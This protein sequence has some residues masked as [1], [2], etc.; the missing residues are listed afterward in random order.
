[1]KP[2]S[3]ARV[4]E[5]TNRLPRLKERLTTAVILLLVGVIMLTTVSFAWLT[6]SQN[7]EATNILTSIASNGNLEIALASG[8]R[9]TVTAPGASQVGDGNLPIVEGNLTWGNMVNLSDPSYGLGNLVLRPASLNV[10]DLL[11]EP[12]KAK[13]YDEAGRPINKDASFRYAKWIQ[14]DVNDQDSPWEFQLSNDLGVRAISST[15]MAA[16]SGYTYNLQL[17]ISAAKDANSAA[18]T[19]YL[20]ITKNYDIVDQ[21]EK[22]FLEA[23]AAVMGAYMTARMN[24]D[25]QSLANA[26]MVKEDMEALRDLFRAFGKVLELERE[27]ML[28]LA[29]LQLFVIYN[30]DTTLYTEFATVDELVAKK[31]QLKSMGLQISGLTQN[32]SD[33]EKLMTNYDKLVTICEKGTIK[34]GDDNLSSIVNSLINVGTC[35]VNGTPV[36]NIGASVAMDLNGKSCKTIITNGILYNFEQRTGARMNV[37]KG[38]TDLEAQY[39]KGLPV[40]AT[41]KVVITVNGTIYALITTSATNPSLFQKDLNYA[42]DLNKGG[43]AELTANDTYGFAIDF[44]VRTN[45]SGSFLTLEGNILTEQIEEDAKGEDAEGNEVQLYTVTLKETDESGEE[46]EYTIDLYMVEGSGGSQTWYNADTHEEYTVDE[47]NPPKKKVIITENIIGYE[48]ENRIWDNNAFLS[49]DN[50]TQ[51]SGSCYVYYAETPEDMA[52][53]LKLLSALN[54][55]FV[56]QNGTLMAEGYMDTVNYFVDNGKVIVPLRL[57]ANSIALQNSDGSETLAI[58]SLDQ[59]VAKLITAIVYLDGTKVE[60]K[61]VLAVSDIQGQL[62]IQFGSSVALNA[63]SDEELASKSMSVSASADVTSF[64]YDT[65]LANGTPMTT[66]LTVNV[67]GSK[68]SNV[69]AFFIRAISS[70]QGIPMNSEDEM[71]IFEDKGGGVW[72]AEYTFTSPGNYVLRSVQVDGIEY[73]LDPETRPQIEVK[74]FSLKSLSWEATTAKEQSFMT[75][76]NSVSAALSLEFVTDDPERM[77]TRVEG[78]F[79]R[80]DGNSVNVVFSRNVTTNQWT[81]KATFLSSGTYTLQYLVFNGEYHEVDASL[82]KVANVYVGMKVSIYTNSPTSF[83]F[84]YGVDGDADNGMTDNEQNLYMQVKIM[85]DTGKEMTRL[86]NVKLYYAMDGYN[87]VETGLNADITWNQSTGYYEGAFETKVG[88]FKFLYVT[89]DGNTITQAT[90]SPRFVI[91]SPEPPKFVEAVNDQYQYAPDN[92]AVLNVCLDNSD[93]IAEEYM[94]GY[95]SDG[96]NLYDVVGVN[97]GE[98]KWSFKIPQLGSVQDG[99]WELQKIH[100]I[101]G[102]IEDEVR[103]DENP[104]VIDMTGK[105]GLKTTVVSTIKVTLNDTSAKEFNGDFLAE[106]KVDWFGITVTDRFDQALEGIGDTV[107]LYYTYQDNSKDYGGYGIDT[108]LGEK[109]LVKKITLNK[110]DGTTFEQSDELVLNHAGT[111]VLTK[112]QFSFMGKGVELEDKKLPTAP[113][114]TV[115]STAP[116]VSIKEITTYKTS[117]MTSDGT[118]ATVYFDYKAENKTIGCTEYTLETYTQPTVTINLTGIGN[119]TKATLTF[120]HAD[121]DATVHLYTSNGGTT[122]VSSYEWTANGTVLRWIGQYKSGSLNITDDTRT[123]AGTLTANEIVL[124]DAAGYSYKVT[125]GSA[126]TINN[127]S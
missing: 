9:Y 119:A 80:T 36:N 104:Y 94:I 109:D 56:D 39:P 41:G 72:E 103:S 62:N 92:D 17:R 43:T 107:T 42:N 15:K 24:S 81:G 58:T 127:P 70:T 84:G 77:P 115:R 61:D 87:K 102:Y 3:N 71:L 19:A 55:A 105:S 34:W 122:A 99:T 26:T 86:S 108:S 65:C 51:G 44:W 10:D 20:N 23:L 66:K 14:T 76:A 11:N 2:E 27:A 125:L 1:M 38:S 67:E 97:Q 25:D 120:A 37:P 110:K 50:T 33:S 18:E 46:I 69:T 112:V 126:I 121:A 16:S 32:L 96:T 28:K 22:P 40:T 45:A 68:A 116:S 35:T 63:L 8:S 47:S 114:I 88:V 52:R 75:A 48:G 95:I 82:Q 6:L 7:P 78:R 53:S 124:T 13:G 64:D 74:G 21:T 60:N 29:N 123:A 113:V 100:V 106:H 12:L 49:T 90:T 31:D 83:L 73:D 111:Y 117:S 57:N 79:L 98:G 5:Y 89:V 101:G 59:N 85:D 91:Q 30:G 118:S 93:G 54:I 4:K